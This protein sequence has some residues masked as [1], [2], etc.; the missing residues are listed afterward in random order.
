MKRDAERDLGPPRGRFHMVSYRDLTVG[1]LHIA[2]VLGKPD[3]KK[4]TLVRVHEP[5]SVIDLLDAEP[6]TLVEH[7]RRGAE[8][9]PAGRQRRDGA[10][11]LQPGEPPAAG[12]RAA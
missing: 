7:R 9:R 1:A 6:G 4:E 10:H 11:E 2:L 8:S 3:A 5:L 12:E